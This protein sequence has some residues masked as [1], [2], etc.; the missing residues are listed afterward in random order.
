MTELTNRKLPTRD[1]YYKNEKIEKML[2]YNEKLDFDL[3]EELNVMQLNKGVFLDI[4]T[5][6]GTQALQLAK[7]RI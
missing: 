1:D 6:T 4:G 2:W 3:E 7:K 5:G